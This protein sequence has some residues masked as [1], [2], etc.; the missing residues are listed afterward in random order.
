MPG[1]F[2]ECSPSVVFTHVWCSAGALVR[3]PERNIHCPVCLYMCFLHAL[4][5]TRTR[6]CDHGRLLACAFVGVCVCVDKVRARARKREG[7]R[8]E[9]RLMQIQCL[10]LRERLRMLFH[11]VQLID[12]VSRNKGRHSTTYTPTHKWTLQ[13]HTFQRT[14]LDKINQKYVAFKEHKYAMQGQFFVCTYTLVLRI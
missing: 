11:R 14:T 8:H 9:F 10:L 4:L 7:H 6:V 5:R 12:M 13:N 1:L 2:L 3:S